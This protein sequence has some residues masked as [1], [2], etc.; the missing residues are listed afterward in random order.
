MSIMTATTVD[1]VAYP[2]ASPGTPVTPVLTSADAPEPGER[3]MSA[4]L[5]GS[6]PDP[7]PEAPARYA[8]LIYRITGWDAFSDPA[9]E[10]VSRL[11]AEDWDSPEDA[12]YDDQ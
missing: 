8:A 7:D 9:R 1:H 11:W 12:A 10:Y 4:V 5:A 2:P 6:Q 3:E